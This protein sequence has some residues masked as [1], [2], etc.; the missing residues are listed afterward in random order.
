MKHLQSHKRRIKV[1]DFFFQRAVYMSIFLTNSKL[2][3]K[4][5]NY[6]IVYFKY[7]LH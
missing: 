7:I 4:A 2:F 3:E 6:I 1:I 5:V